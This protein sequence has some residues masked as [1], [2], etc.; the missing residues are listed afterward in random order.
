MVTENDNIPD[1]REVGQ[2]NVVH[3]FV[4]LD[5]LIANEVDCTQKVDRR[6]YVESRSI[7]ILENSCNRIIPFTPEVGSRIV[8]HE[9]TGPKIKLCNRDL[10][11]VKNTSSYIWTTRKANEYVLP[12]TTV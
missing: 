10:L 12:F 11:S 8:V 1:I 9:I 5:K 3:Q 7:K 6:T 4:Y 2:C